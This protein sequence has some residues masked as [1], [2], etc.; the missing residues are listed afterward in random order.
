MSFY[1]ISGNTHAR[2]SSD[3]I[4]KAGSELR[5]SMRGSKHALLSLLYVLIWVL[6]WL[7]KI[8]GQEVSDVADKH[9]MDVRPL[10]GNSRG[11]L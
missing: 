8:K 6:P 9:R 11:A 10:C 1:T 5:P 7:H 3:L 2:H 4:W